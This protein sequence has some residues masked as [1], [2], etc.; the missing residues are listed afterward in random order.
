MWILFYFCPN[1]FW[2]AKPGENLSIS[3]VFYP[4]SLYRV[5]WQRNHTTQSLVKRFNAS[6]IWRMIQITQ[7]TRY[8]VLQRTLLMKN[9]DSG[10][11][12]DKENYVKWKKRKTRPGY[13]NLSILPPIFYKRGNPNFFW[14]FRY[15]NDVI[16]TYAY[17][18]LEVVVF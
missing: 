12:C 3:C 8:S 6:S 18:E 11:N 16:L 5:Q 4:S 17:H 1:L 15:K 2:Q 9:Q 14:C 7:K 13:S 10:S